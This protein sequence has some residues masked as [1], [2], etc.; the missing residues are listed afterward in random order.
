MLFS[1]PNDKVFKLLND[2]K[3]GDW[4]HEQLFDCHVYPEDE[5]G[6]DPTA[7]VVSDVTDI[8]DPIVDCVFANR[9]SAKDYC[10]QSKRK[11]V[12]EAADWRE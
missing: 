1:I 10:E 6:Q 3:H 2:K 5:E 11:L 8:T 4:L 9:V 12:F 7:W